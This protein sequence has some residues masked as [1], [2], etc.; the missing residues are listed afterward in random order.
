MDTF[1]INNLGIL[2]AQLDG[3]ICLRRDLLKGGGNS[4][5]LLDKGNLQMVGKG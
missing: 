2:A 5:N 1:K 3:H 4:D